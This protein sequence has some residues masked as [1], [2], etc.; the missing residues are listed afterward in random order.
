MT[1]IGTRSAII[2]RVTEVIVFVIAGLGMTG[3]TRPIH[4]AVL[5]LIGIRKAVC[6]IA[7]EAWNCVISTAGFKHDRSQASG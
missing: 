5:I 1:A 3:L 6:V 7:E 2:V 4:V